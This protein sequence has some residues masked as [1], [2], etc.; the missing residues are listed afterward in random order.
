ML[1]I[2]YFLLVIVT[3]Q[4][5]P[6]MLGAYDLSECL[7]VKEYLDRRGYEVSSCEILSYPQEDAKKLEVPHIPTEEKNK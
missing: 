7:A 6:V 5:H 1:Q 4:E 2:A 3:W